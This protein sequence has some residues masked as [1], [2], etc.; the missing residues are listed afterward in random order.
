MKDQELKKDDLLPGQM[1]SEDHYIYRAPGRLYHTNGKSDPY[2][3]FS[4]VFILVDRNNGYVS[5]KHQVAINATEIVKT[6]LSLE[7]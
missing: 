5:I 4:G 6:K 7:R 3:L 2:G 1:L